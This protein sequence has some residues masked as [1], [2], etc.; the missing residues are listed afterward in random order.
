MHREGNGTIP[1]FHKT[2]SSPNPPKFNNFSKPKSV[3]M[4]QHPCRLVLIALLGAWTGLALGDTEADRDWRR[5][6]HP[7]LAKHC[8]S[9]HNAADK[10]AGLDLDVFYYVPSVIGRGETWRNIVEMVRNEEMPPTG[11]PRMTEAEKKAFITKVN[12][13]LD[14]ALVEPDPGPSVIRRLSHRE[15]TYTVKDLL[16]VDFFA[17]DFFPNEGS[18][19]EGFDNQSRVL[20]VTPLMME[21]YYM[22]A[23]SIIRAI[24]SDEERW[25]RVVPQRYRPGPIRRLVHW[26]RGAFTDGPQV[27]GRPQRR[28]ARAIV[29]FATRAFRGFLAPE[30]KTEL[31]AFFDEIYFGGLW[32]QAHGFDEALATT[33]KRILVSPLFLYRTEVNLP[34]HKPYAISNLELASRMS[35]LLWSSLPDDTLVQTA[36][37]EDLHDPTVLN[38]EA[39]R[40]MRSP[41]FKRFADSFAPQWLGV[42]EAL[43][44]AQADQEIFPEFTGAIREAMKQEVVDYFYH[45]LTQRGNLLE[46][47]DSDYTLLNDD[48]AGHY[49]IPGVQGDHFRPVTVA[50]HGRGGILGMGAVLTAT[51]LPTRTSPVLR[52]QWV[53]EQVLGTPPPPPPPDV[54]ELAL[55]KDQAQDELDMRAILEQHR[56]SPNCA[57]CH[58]KMDPIGFALE[59]F[60]AVGRWRQYYRGEVTI[61]AS[62]TLPSGQHI[63][64]PQALRQALAGEKEKFAKNFSRK[65]MSYA[66]G[67]GIGFI[68]SPTLDDL[69]D[70]LLDS[71]FNTEEMMLTMVN[72]YPFRHRR[73]DMTDLYLKE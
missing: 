63:D 3:A 49:G 58:Q 69:T 27:W 53:L 54:P 45:V 12:E 56:A 4:P 19:G 25:R 40:M 5:V 17:Q 8:T 48:L 46:L 28:A 24:R 66:L 2:T 71:N 65:L 50:D 21:R 67:R 33:F 47:V 15:Y 32:R 7:I 44:T 37:R 11:Q 55:E 14:G 30:D 52:G 41:K 61:D 57:G 13:V 36:Y 31:L 6:M 10:K 35:Y 60:D 59:N 39:R 68:D 20:F 73:S 64:G 1:Q 16:D 9:C 72:S 51:S 38:R 42:E 22:A 26:V 29:P 62:A 70:R 34:I 18:G 43:A 23:D